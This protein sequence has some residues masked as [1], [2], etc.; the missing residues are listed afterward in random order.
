MNMRLILIGPPG[1]G[2]GTIAVL[3]EEKYQIP[4]ISTGDLFRE[5]ISKKTELGQL[6]SQ[7]I[8]DGKLVPDEIT[9][10]M[11]AHRLI[12]PDAENGF[13][14][15]GFP[16]TIAQAEAL[17]DMLQWLGKEL[18]CVIEVI[19]PDNI[20]IERISSRRVCNQCGR[21]YNLIHLPPQK[22]G[23]CD[24][25]QGTLIQREDDREDVVQTRLE[26]YRKSTAPL[27]EYFREQGKL[28]VIDNSGEVKPLLLDTICN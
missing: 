10:E 28:S 22:P 23:Q 27:I 17:S 14:L 7:Y 12:R 2:K 15:D 24:A 25:C 4:Q 20:I 5:N 18:D 6:A 19:C 1:A 26:T 9:C 11:V 16:R 3:L 13:I 21:S 8:S